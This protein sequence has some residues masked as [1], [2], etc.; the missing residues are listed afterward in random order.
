MPCA[1]LC[2]EPSYE[3]RKQSG[4]DKRRG[5]GDG[6]GR[7]PAVRGRGR[8]GGS[9][10]HQSGRAEATARRIADAG[11]RAFACRADVSD[12]GD[13]KAAVDATVSRFG[14]LDILYNN[15]GVDIEHAPTADYSIELFDR[16]I[17]INLRGVFLGMKFA[18]P[19]MTGRGGSIINTASVV[20]FKVMPGGVA[21]C[22]S[23]GAVVAM[24]QVAA[25]EYGPAKVRVNCICPGAIET[26]MLAEARR[27]M[28]ADMVDHAANFAPL[29]RTGKAEEI[30]NM[31][32]FLASDESSFITGGAFTVDG[33]S[34]A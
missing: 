28:G 22:A 34:L 3:T 16:T 20:A 4:S 10:G 18:I 31:A 11:G 32:L 21:Y 8:R 5:D 17:A 19:H 14:K 13:V 6:R 24:T 33:G 2:E 12:P 26:P 7:G 29:R 1:C 30:A 9:G 15:A 25:V 27:R 23:K